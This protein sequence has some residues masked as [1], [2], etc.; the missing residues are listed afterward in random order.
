MAPATGGV[1]PPPES[2]S[3]RSIPYDIKDDTI[4]PPQRHALLHI[5][6]SYEAGVPCPLIVAL[7]GKGQPAKEFEYHTQLSNAAFNADSIVVYPEGVDLQWTGD[8]EAPPRDEVDDIRFI[9]VLIDHVMRDYTVDATRVYVAGFSNGGG[10]AALLACDPRASAGIAA[11]AMA[12]AAVYRDEALKEPLFSTCRPSRLPVPILEFH[13]DADPVIHYEGK[14]TPD[15]PTYDVYEWLQG[16]AKR[17]GCV[18]L[19]GKR[20]FLHGGKV[21]KIVWSTPG[22]GDHSEQHVEN[23]VEHYKIAGFGHGWPSRYPL[24]NDSQ[25]RHGPTYFDATPLVMEF[26]RRFKRA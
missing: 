11:F 26:F 5:P 25:E 4:R 12:S 14:T 1:A 8:P 19:E 24:N 20:V 2:E 16:W 15:G 17:N 23:V 3:H 18:D 21:E 6:D 10:L 7:H 9:D 13:G 22:K